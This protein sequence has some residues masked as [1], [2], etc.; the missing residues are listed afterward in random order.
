MRQKNERP[1][2]SCARSGVSSF[3]RC[4]WKRVRMQR[5]D[6]VEKTYETASTRNG[7]ARPTAKSAPPTG[8]APSR[9]IAPRACVTLEA[10]AS[11][12]SGTTARNAPLVA[13][14]EEHAGRRVDER[15]D[16][17]RPVRRRCASR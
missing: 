4:S 12:A 8:G 16:D 3:A 14:A 7:I 9:T 1:S 2:A 11:C 5:R 6:A 15:D 10:S 17:D 13:G